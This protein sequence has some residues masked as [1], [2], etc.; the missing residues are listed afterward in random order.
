MSLN[1][2]WFVLFVVIIVGYLILDGFDLG[3]GILHP[4]VARNDTERRVL[5]NSIGPVW[6][7]NEVWLVLGGG[8]LFAAFPLVY[9]SLFSGFYFAMMLVLVCLILRTVAIEFRSK[10]PGARWRAGWDWVFF[11]SSAGLS[12]LLGV[13]FGN[14]IR[15]VPL[16]QQGNINISLIDLLSPFALLVGVTT[17]AMFATHGAI[18]LTMKTEGPLLERVLRWLPVLMCTFFV[19][20]T[21]VVLGTLFLGLAITSPY[22]AQPWLAVFPAAALVALVIAWWLLRRRQY[23]RAFVASSAMIALLIFSAAAGI[24]PN[25]LLSTINP[26]YNLTIYNAASQPNTLTVMLIIAVI[27]L[28]FVLLYTAGVYYIFRG[29]VKLESASY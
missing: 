16:D 18:Y 21:L 29:K 17:V 14:V 27:G 13:A 20:N 4:F 25:L 26:A 1:F 3:V 9:A 7:G 23:F 28:P 22:L 24:F 2:I 12:L 6:D 5:L 19:L 15:G 10:R 11:G 8:A